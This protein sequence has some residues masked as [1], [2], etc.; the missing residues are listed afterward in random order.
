M[1]YLNF[2]RRTKL[3]ILYHDGNDSCS[4]YFLP[5]AYVIQQSGSLYKRQFFIYSP[6]VLD[7]YEIYTL[8]LSV[9][10]SANVQFLTASYACTGT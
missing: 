4:E 3:S 2:Q 6:A 8:P 7:V 9:R 10:T 1:W 5:F